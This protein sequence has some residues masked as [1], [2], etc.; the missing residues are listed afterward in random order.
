MQGNST[1]AGFGSKYHFGEA[2][3]RTKLRGQKMVEQVIWVFFVN[4]EVENA[5]Y[6]PDRLWCP[7]K[8]RPIKAKKTQSIA[9]EG[10]EQNRGFWQAGK[11]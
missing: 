7:E 8:K 4:F 3:G 1:K 6:R 9:F 10:R 2:S 11:V 5:L